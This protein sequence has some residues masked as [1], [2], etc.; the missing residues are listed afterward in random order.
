VD[1]TSAPCNFTRRNA[2]FLPFRLFV[3]LICIATNDV[4][5]LSPHPSQTAVRRRPP[6]WHTT[7]EPPDDPGGDPAESQIPKKK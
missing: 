3:L 4:F 1:S 2:C 6:G 5:L 7:V